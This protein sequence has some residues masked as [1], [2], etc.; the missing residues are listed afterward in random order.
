MTTSATVDYNALD[1]EAFRREVR[2]FVEAHY[3]QHLRYLQ[4][5]LRPA[6]PGSA[7]SSK[8][9]SMQRPPAS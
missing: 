4:R 1:D 9:C 3:P 5:R 7:T 6:E 8:G 2:A